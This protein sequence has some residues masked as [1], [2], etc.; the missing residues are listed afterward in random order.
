MYVIFWWLDNSS[1][2]LTLLK[3]KLPS[4]VLIFL[5]I[6]LITSVI[7]STK[8]ATAGK[9]TSPVIGKG[10]EIKTSASME[11]V[12]DIGGAIARPGLYTLPY[13]SRIGDLITQAGGLAVEA[14]PSYVAFK[15]NLAQQLSDGQKI[16]IPTLGSIA[17]TQQPDDST[18]S[19]NSA[20]KSDL[21]KLPGI[22]ST[23]AELILKSRPYADFSDLEKRSGVKATALT[24]IKDL[25][26][27]Y[28][29]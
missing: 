21:E 8:A 14:D 9:A 25:I 22:G 12:V 23:Y 5:I 15:L 4:L 2:L 18:L 29:P 3:E 6:T 11:V 28:G 7:T 16:T 19:V 10:V 1:S 26:N 13:G 27:F 24:K 17:P 20:S